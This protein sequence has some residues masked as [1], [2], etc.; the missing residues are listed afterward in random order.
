MNSLKHSRQREAIHAFLLQ[1]TDHPTAE[2]IYQTL[3]ETY[4]RLSLGTVY[5]NLTLL[6]EIGRIRTIVTRDGIAHY[7]GNMLPHIHYVCNCCGSV[8]DIF[9]PQGLQDWE[10]TLKNQCPGTIETMITTIYGTCET[11]DSDET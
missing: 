7:D 1:R 2:V 5:R 10:D 11:C 3:K 6:E 8:R 4:P 9:L